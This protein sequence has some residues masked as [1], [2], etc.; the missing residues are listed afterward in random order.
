MKKLLIL[1][2]LV[3]I[4]CAPKQEKKV[5]EQ[6]RYLYDLGMSAYYAKNYSE[7]IARLYEA[8][9][10]APDRPKVWNALGLT[11]MEVE[12]FQKAE[13]AFKNALR[14][15]PSYSE[16]KMNLGILYAKAKDYKKAI[17]YLSQ[18]L[19]DEAFEKKH[20]AFYY[21]AKVYKELGNK[22]KYLDFL[23]KATAYNPMFLEAQTELASAYLDEKRYEDAE[24]LY[25]TLISNNFK[26][27]DILLGLARVYYETGKY[28]RAKEVIRQVLEN[29]QAN[30]LQRSQAYDLL[31]KILVEEQ[32]KKLSSSSLTKLPHVES[33]S[34]K[35]QQKP[36][37]SE[38][39]KYAVQIAAFSTEKGAKTLI[40]KLRRR[41]LGNLSVVEVSGIYKVVYGKFPTREEAQRELE[42]LKDMDIYGFIVEVE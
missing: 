9:K 38:R 37:P 18:A 29:K 28:T 5:Q 17:E 4:S 21:L 22:E 20:I 11:Y 8:T 35:P 36:K 40:E 1:T 24:R 30:N 41:G 7:A 15:D 3:V 13:K 6:W 42:K 16:A 12:E 10:V 34:T 23:K 31:S 25:R 2:A 27:P 39:G 14:A 26:L 32:R 33:R 19:K